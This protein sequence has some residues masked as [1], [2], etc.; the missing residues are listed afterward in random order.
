MLCWISFDHIWSSW[1]AAKRYT[2]AHLRMQHLPGMLL[3]CYLHVNCEVLHSSVCLRHEV[4]G[5]ELIH[6]FILKTG[7]A[8]FCLLPNCWDLKATASSMVRLRKPGH[9]CWFSAHVSLLQCLLQLLSLDGR[10]SHKVLVY[11]L[12]AIFALLL[13]TQDIADKALRVSSWPSWYSRWF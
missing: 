8:R 10:T 2:V 4:K 11:L 6:L 9:V 1:P 13:K 5:R 12:Q 7:F 3:I